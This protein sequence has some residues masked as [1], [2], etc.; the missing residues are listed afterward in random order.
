MLTLRNAPPV[1]QDR[2]SYKDDLP[3]SESEIFL[4]KGLDTPQLQVDCH[5]VICPSRLGK[6]LLL[7]GKIELVWGNDEPSGE[8]FPEST[9][10]GLKAV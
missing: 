6:N 3:D 7:A 1:G 2:A 4:Q 9:Q 10:E 5:K 8:M